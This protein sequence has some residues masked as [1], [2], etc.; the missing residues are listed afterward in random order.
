VATVTAIVRTIDVLMLAMKAIKGIMSE[1]CWMN[2]DS[3]VER[4]LNYCT[5]A[6]HIKAHT[7]KEWMNIQYP[8]AISV[9]H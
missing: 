8:E 7:C 1:A 6:P 2:V 9:D 3:I 4:W 5:E